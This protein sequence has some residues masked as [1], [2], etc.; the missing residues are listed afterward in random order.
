MPKL[1]IG[2]SGW[3]YQHWRGL[4]YPS[5]LPQAK[6]LS[7]YSQHFGTVEV[8]NSF[9]RLPSKAAFECWCKQTPNDFI[10]SVKGNRF[11]THMRKLRS[12]EEPLQR[13]FDAVCGLGEKLKVI[14]WQLPPMLKADP[15]RLRSFL[16]M[17]PSEYRHTVEFRHL[18]WWSDKATLKVLEEFGCAF[19]IP[20]A[21]MLPKYIIVTADFSYI[22]MHGWNQLYSGCYP[23]EELQWWAERIREITRSN[24]DVF[25]YFNNDVHAYA[26]RNAEELIQ[27]LQ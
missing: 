20:S 16:R 8:N 21:P 4:F 1:F 26:V 9:Y 23:I 12:V 22:R 11:I 13:F 24:V 25:V 27:L 5:D 10:F 7:F 2:T 3:V 17:L 15:D 14:L 18:S 6:W 19:C